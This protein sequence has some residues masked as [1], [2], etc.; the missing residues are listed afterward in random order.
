MSFSCMLCWYPLVGPLFCLCVTPFPLPSLS[1]L[2]DRQLVTEGLLGWQR[3]HHD[4]HALRHSGGRVH[5]CVPARHPPWP[6]HVGQ[7]AG[8][9]CPQCSTE[10]EG[11]G[12]LWVGFC[13]YWF[14]HLYLSNFFTSAASHTWLQS[15]V[16]AI[17]TKHCFPLTVTFWELQITT[18]F[19]FVFLCSSAVA[20][21][22]NK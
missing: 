6:G 12:L 8:A 15:R 7:G 18:F 4:D 22:L 1:L 10:A 13:I 21:P 17:H 20:F 14:L 2:K 5:E 19:S 9:G 16:L 3:A 11:G